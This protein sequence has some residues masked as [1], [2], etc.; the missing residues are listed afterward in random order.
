MG[1]RLN[2]EIINLAVK[3]LLRNYLV[4][5]NW[6]RLRLELQDIYRKATGENMAVLSIDNNPMATFLA[7]PPKIVTL[8]RH[9]ASLHLTHNEHKANY[10]TVEA[11]IQ[12]GTYPD[13]EWVSPEQR[14]KAVDTGDVWM[15]QWYPH[16]PVGFCRLI[17]CDLQAL[18]EAASPESP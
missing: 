1:E 17:A 4:P 10:E 5:R 13:D 3:G 11:A 16:T 6:E 12:S 7:E 2:N 14:A 8:P 15:L 9:D 18:L